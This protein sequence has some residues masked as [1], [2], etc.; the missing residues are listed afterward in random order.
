MAFVRLVSSATARELSVKTEHS[1]VLPSEIDS[2]LEGHND[3]ATE[4][5]ELLNIAIG[6]EHVL[7]RDTTGVWSAGININGQLG[8]GSD[9]LSKKACPKW[10]RVQYFENDNMPGMEIKEIH[11]TATASFVV[12]EDAS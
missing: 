1:L 12:A 2:P 3:A 10:R 5:N 6:R 4:E 8:L 7:M 9:T 11:A